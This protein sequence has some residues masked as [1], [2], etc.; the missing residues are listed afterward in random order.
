MSWIIAGELVLLYDNETRFRYSPVTLSISGLRYFDC[1]DPSPRYTQEKNARSSGKAVNW[2]NSN[3]LLTNLKR[4]LQAVSSEHGRVLVYVWAVEQDELSKRIIPQGKSDVVDVG[5][6]VVVPWVSSKQNAMEGP[7][8][9]GG[10]QEQVYN[11][12]YHMF[13]KGE[14]TGLVHE[15][16]TGLNLIVGIATGQLPSTEGVEIV[17]DGWERSNYYVELRRWS[18][19]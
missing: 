7:D 14:L 15:A 2:I 12:Y 4:L 11:R 19:P 6:D 8:P 10:I 1:N 17:Q 16:A 13:A 3:R 5:K 18:I 9:S